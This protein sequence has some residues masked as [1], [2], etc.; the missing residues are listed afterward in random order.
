RP[1]R[2]REQEQLE[3]QPPRGARAPARCGLAPRRRRE[4]DPA[5]VVHGELAHRRHRGR[6]GAGE[7]RSSGRRPPEGARR[8]RGA[9][10]AGRGRDRRVQAAPL[11]RARVGAPG[12]RR[13]ATPSD[14]AR[15]LAIE[16]ALVA[17]TLLAYAPIVRNGFTTLD[18]DVYVTAN[19]RVLSGLSWT[20]AGWAFTTGH[21]ANW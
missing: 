10:D 17:T 5:R 15:P 12:R 1:D 8:A 3:Q 6:I 9:R 11:A 7:P 4:R 20:N 14:R 13:M 18:D 19:P 16:A 2:D 21:A